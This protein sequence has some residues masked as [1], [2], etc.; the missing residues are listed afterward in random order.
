MKYLCLVYGEEKDIE[1]MTDDECMAYDRALRNKGKCLASKALQPAHSAANVRV[2]DEKCLSVT[3][4]SPRR[5]NSWP[6]S[7]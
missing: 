6:V 2:R 3:A 7:I 4:L 1:A 5:K